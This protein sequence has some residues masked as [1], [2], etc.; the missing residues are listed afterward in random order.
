MEHPLHIPVL[1][2][3]LRSLGRQTLMEELMS[4][5]QRLEFKTLFKILNYW[6]KHMSKLLI[7]VVLNKSAVVYLV[8]HQEE[9]VL[10]K[11]NGLTLNVN[12]LESPSKSQVQPDKELL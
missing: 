8:T 5:L 12:K 11:G 1:M 3:E 10:H 6:A 7:V 9:L 2:M 4:K